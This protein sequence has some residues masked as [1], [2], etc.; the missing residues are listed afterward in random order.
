M[1]A[2]VM[3]LATGQQLVEMQLNTLSIVLRVR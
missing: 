2:L 3:V 1:V